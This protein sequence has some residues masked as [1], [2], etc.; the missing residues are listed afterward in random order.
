MKTLLKFLWA[1]QIKYDFDA[2]KLLI[3][4]KLCYAGDNLKEK[5]CSWSNSVKWVFKLHQ[6][7]R[8]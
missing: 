5:T 7:L 3:N 2:D 8:K 4:W 6:E 1:A